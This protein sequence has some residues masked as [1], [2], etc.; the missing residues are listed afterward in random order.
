MSDKVN[1][2]LRVSDTFES[3]TREDVVMHIRF[4]EEDE[5]FEYA[6]KLASELM[7]QQGLGYRMSV[8]TIRNDRGVL[9][10]GI[11]KY[12]DCS[13]LEWACR[14]TVEPVIGPDEADDIVCSKILV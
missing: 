7:S 6:K 4:A 11:S 2:V 1:Y 13:I 3:G 14:M 8:E 9:S 5:A 12:R 10:C